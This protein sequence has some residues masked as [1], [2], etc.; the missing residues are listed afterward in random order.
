MQ[1]ELE[2]IQRDK[3]PLVSVN[4]DLEKAS[5]SVWIDGLLLKLQNI[6]K[7]EKLLS[8]LQAFLSNRLS[9]TKI[10]NYHSNN[11]PIHIGLPQGSVLA[12][13]FFI[14]FIKEFI[15][16]YP[17]RFKFADDGAL[18]VTADDTLQLAYRTQAAADIEGFMATNGAWLF[19][20]PKLR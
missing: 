8:I 13:T 19:M 14:L 7:T 3:K 6:G 5:D 17:I 4:I 16:A 10:G 9:F 15:D 12:P 1:L 2:D 20:V 11:F 18:I